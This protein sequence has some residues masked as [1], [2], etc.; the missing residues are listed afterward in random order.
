MSACFAK[1]SSPALITGTSSP[2]SFHPPAFTPPPPSSSPSK[3]SSA[4]PSSS[5]P[6][7][8]ALQGHNTLCP[9]AARFRPQGVLKHRHCANQR[10][11]LQATIPKPSKGA[12]WFRGHTHGC[13]R[14]C[15]EK[16]ARRL[17]SQE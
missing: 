6:S 8:L 15:L 1:N 11:S 4:N 13:Y 12:H 16:E 10:T 17:E 3:C 9:F 7:F 5:A 2:S 14:R